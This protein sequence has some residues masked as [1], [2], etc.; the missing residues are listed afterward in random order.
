MKQRKRKSKT[1]VHVSFDTVDK[2]IPRVP[3]QRC[4]NEDSITPRICV[5]P[6]LTSALQAI[7]QAGEVI[8]N[9]KRLGVPVIVH[10]YYLECDSILNA[11]EINVP[12]ACVTGEMW[13]TDTPSKVYR[14]D[15]E[16]TDSYTV[17]RKDK[18]GT[19]GRLLLGARYKRVR[20]QNNWENLAYHVCQTNVKAEEFLEKMPSIT[21]RTFM[22]NLDDELIKCMNIK[23][24]KIEF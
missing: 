15:Y 4:I 16:L 18:C 19:E 3:R 11:N 10:A 8:Y 21:F 23:P 1:M 20:F 22:S 24:K 2:F 12:D 14:C 13:L 17:L 5:A 9:M 7:P 6:D